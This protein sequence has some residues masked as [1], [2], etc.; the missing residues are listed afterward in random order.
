M[1]VM[2]A[3]DGTGARVLTIKR[4]CDAVQ[5]GV[6]VERLTLFTPGPRSQQLI[7]NELHLRVHPG[8]A[9]KGHTSGGSRDQGFVGFECLC[10]KESMMC[11]SDWIQT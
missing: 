6:E 7:A 1:G 2:G 4:I 9:C 8:E 5:Q 10:G 11:G 3:A